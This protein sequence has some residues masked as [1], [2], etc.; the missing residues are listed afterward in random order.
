MV[1]I[2]MIIIGISNAICAG[3][4]RLNFKMYKYTYVSFLTLA[5]VRLATSFISHGYEFFLAA[6]FS[7]KPPQD[8]NV[9]LRFRSFF[10]KHV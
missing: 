3:R 9:F 6:E 2:T 5:V 4:T 1:R 10:S 7:G 8:V